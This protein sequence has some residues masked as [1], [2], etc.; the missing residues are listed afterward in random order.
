MLRAPENLLFELGPHLFS[1]VADIFG[2][3]RDI[4]VSLRNPITLPG[5]LVHHQSW[6]INGTARG[7]SVTLNLSLVEGHDNRSVRLRGLGALAHYDFAEDA[8]RIEKA[9]M[10][11]IVIGPFAPGVQMRFARS[12]R[13]MALRP[14]ASRFSAPSTASI[15]R[16]PPA[17]RSIAVCPRASPAMRRR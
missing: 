15:H 13:L 9:A 5:G 7:A 17:R 1:F 10:Q 6:R 14:T 16:S 4:E 8:Y 2:E 12:S 11:D 3:L